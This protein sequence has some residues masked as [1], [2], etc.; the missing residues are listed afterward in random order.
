MLWVKDSA[1]GATVQ[2]KNTSEMYDPRYQA[3]MGINKV[4]YLY[5]K[6]DQANF[7]VIYGTPYIFVETSKKPRYETDQHRR[8]AAHHQH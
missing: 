2:G 7:F 3:V 4:L 8:K 6:K 5:N 1:P